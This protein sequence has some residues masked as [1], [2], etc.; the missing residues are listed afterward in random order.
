MTEIPLPVCLSSDLRSPSPLSHMGYNRGRRE[1]RWVMPH[2][3]ECDT[4]LRLQTVWS[5]F[6]LTQCERGHIVC[7]QCGAELEVTP[8]SGALQV[9][10]VM[11]VALT[12]IAAAAVMA[13]HEVPTTLVV[14]TLVAVLASVGVASYLF[15]SRFRPRKSLSI[16]PARGRIGKLNDIL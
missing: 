9:V 13:R 12:M 6:T 4:S 3:P 15:L 16:S 5:G 7:P 8:A 11:I 14:L 2:C 1:A 10:V